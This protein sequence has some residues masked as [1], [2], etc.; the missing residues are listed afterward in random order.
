MC[1]ERAAQLRFVSH[2]WKFDHRGRKSMCPELETYPERTCVLVLTNPRAGRRGRA[3]LVGPLVEKLAA[4]G[5]RPEVLDDLGL[6]GELAAARLAQGTL[7][8]CLAVGGDGT[9]AELI[10]RTPHETPIAVLPVGT[11][12]LLAKYLGVPRNTDFVAQLLQRYR[13]ERVDAATANGRLFFL[14]ASAGFDAAVVHRMAAMRQGALSYWSYAKPIWREIRS[15]QYPELTVYCALQPD[16][17][18]VAYASR[19][20]WVVNVPAYAGGLHFAPHASAQDGV[21]DICMLS[22]GG[23]RRSLGYLPYL[24]LARADRLRDCRMVQ[25]TKV[26]IEAQVPVA[27]QLDGDPGGMLPVDICVAPQRVTL[28]VPEHFGSPPRPTQFAA[29]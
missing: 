25:A 16:E 17:P 2:F 12:N 10:N 5:M 24:W 14:M 20:V 23:L 27:Y 3:D 21:L 9:V 19:W 11:A 15:Y 29:G 28:V 7:R 18:A 22:R 4:R 8:A 1:D 26:R 6:V 13:L